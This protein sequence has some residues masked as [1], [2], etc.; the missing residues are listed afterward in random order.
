MPVV[1]RAGRLQIRAALSRLPAILAGLEHDPTGLVADLHLAVGSVALSLIR[2]AFVTRAAGGTDEAGLRWEPL[3]ESTAARRGLGAQ[4]LRDTGILLNSLSPLGPDNV[5]EARPG[6]IA[7]GTNVPYASYHHEGTP[8]M[9]ARPL[10]PDPATWPDSWWAQIT[11]AFL[12]G[13]KLVAAELVKQA[14]AR[15]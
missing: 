14:G 3:A 5:L 6:T 10:W 9:P 7:I 12:D 2:E 1:V 13:A 11:A 15:R 8:R 4:I